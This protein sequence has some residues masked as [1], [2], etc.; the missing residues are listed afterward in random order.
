MV[1]TLDA[2]TQLGCIATAPSGAGRAKAVE[3][4]KAMNRIL[5]VGIIGA[6]ADRGWARESHVPA[7][8]HL[9][10]L[11]LAAVANRDQETAD[12]AARAFGVGKAYGCA[13]DLLRDPDIDIVAVAVTL[14][15]HRDL[16]LGALAA[17][18]HV[19]CEYPLGLDVAQS[20]ELA[21]AAANSGV[22][23]AI[24]L[25]ARCSAAVR[26]AGELIAS[27]AIGR[28]LAARVRSPTI[29]FGPTTSP[30]EAYTEKPEN[31][32]T[33]VTIQGAHTL[34]LLLLLLGN[35]MEVAALASTQFPE[36]RIG[37]GA[38]QKRETFDHLLVQ[39]RSA[40]GAAVSVEVAG[41]QRPGTPFS[42]EVTG[43][44]GVL[45]LDG[46]APRG[47]QSGRLRLAINGR[48]QAVSEGEVA[49]LSDA[50]ANVA[51]LYA[52]LRDDIAHATRT[53]PDFD[54]AVRVARLVEAVAT[55]ARTGVRQ[56]CEG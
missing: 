6:N 32:V 48:E 18:K 44:T 31:G 19:C 55:S 13:D 1:L 45:T 41:G 54:H 51:G 8:Q 39:A 2:T 30:A 36:I 15:G 34:D 38:L 23:A 22:H 29:G 52:A 7:V 28:P 16:V 37:N 14:R 56:S 5:R 10:G 25:Q 9:A 17:G 53:V 40:G 27:G 12:A 3:K 42:L 49:A 43:E 47:F 46:G 4:G 11:E 21:A 20:R 33:L 24:G 50:A 26:R 35:L